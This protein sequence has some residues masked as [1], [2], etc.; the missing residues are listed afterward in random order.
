MKEMLTQKFLTSTSCF[1]CLLGPPRSPPTAALLGYV[2][3]TAAASTPASWKSLPPMFN[4]PGSRSARFV[5]FCTIGSPPSRWLLYPLRLSGLVA[6][7]RRVGLRESSTC[8]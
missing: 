5:A 7:I 3:V 8:I 4:L 6:N 2:V 1:T